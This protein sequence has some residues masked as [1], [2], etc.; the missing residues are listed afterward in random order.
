MFPLIPW[1]GEGWAD[2]NHQKVEEDKGFSEDKLANPFSFLCQ[3]IMD[4]L[5]WLP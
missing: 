5:Y 4:N 3:G 1:P 2:K